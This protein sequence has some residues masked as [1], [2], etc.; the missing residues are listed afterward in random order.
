[1]AENHIIIIILVMGCYVFFYIHRKKVNGLLGDLSRQKKVIDAMESRIQ[2]FE[3]QNRKRIIN[4]EKNKEIRKYND[5]SDTQNQ[6]RFIN[7][8]DLHVQNPVNREA[9]QVLY[10]LDEWIKKFRPEW[11]FSFEVSM[12]AFIRTTYSQNDPRQ[13]QAFNSY[14]GKRVD[15]LLID[16]F[17]KPVLVVEYHGSGHNL[18]DNAEERMAVKRLALHKAGIPL[19][20]IPENMPRTGIIAAISDVVE[21][22]PSRFGSARW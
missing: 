20:E 13:K 15:F 8:C 12:G 5:I 2:F 9:S 1:M 4:Y 18:S 22:A 6:L 10:A 21:A 19:L 16:R 17:G 7:E 3:I 14:S 11:R